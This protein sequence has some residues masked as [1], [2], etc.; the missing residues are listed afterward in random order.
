VKRLWV[1]WVGVVLAVLFLSVL[2]GGTASAGST[3]ANIYANNSWQPQGGVVY[4]PQGQRVAVSPTGT[5]SNGS[6]LDVGPQGYTASQSAHFTP[7]CKYQ[8]TPNLPFGRLIALTRVSSTNFHIWDAGYARYIY[9]PGRLYFRMNERD[10]PC[11]ENNWG[12]LSVNVYAG[13][14]R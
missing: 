12:W 4:I 3:S 11:L 9:G 14:I 13:F 5:W 1:V 6:N 10:G 2:S 7:N 8:R